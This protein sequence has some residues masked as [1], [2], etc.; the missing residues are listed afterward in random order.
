MAGFSYGIENMT[1]CVTKVLPLFN[2]VLVFST[3]D[4]TYHGHPNPLQCPE[5]MTRKSLA[6]YYFSNGRPAEEVSGA[7]S[8]LFKARSHDD[9]RPTMRQKARSVAWDILPPIVTRQIRGLKRSTQK[10][11]N[12]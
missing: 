7:H 12:A 11:D 8:T 5:D 1:C 4:F 2:R 10:S 9:F 3:T 6:L